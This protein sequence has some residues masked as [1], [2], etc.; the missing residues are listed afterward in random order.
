MKIVDSECPYRGLVPGSEELGTSAVA[1]AY[2]SLE[3]VVRPC[4]EVVALA[5]RARLAEREDRVQLLEREAV[6]FQCK[7][8]AQQ[9]CV[10][11][12]R[13]PNIIPNNAS[14]SQVPLAFRASQDNQKH[15]DQCVSGDM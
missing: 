13:D 2:H 5:L 6:L 4:V 7:P 12:G 11:P 8:A 1:L 10:G 14:N 3:V 9:S 15:N